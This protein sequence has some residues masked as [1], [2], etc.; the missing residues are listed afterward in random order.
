MSER[1]EHIFKYMEYEAINDAQHDLVIKYESF[2]DRN[3]YLS[4][5]QLEVLE[6]IFKQAAENY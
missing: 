6:S 2:Y 1:I 4:D 3:G 5:A